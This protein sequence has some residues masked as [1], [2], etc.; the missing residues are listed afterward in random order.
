MPT[1]VASCF[2]GI[3]SSGSQS[4]AA[5]PVRSPSGSSIGW[6]L[7]CL[8]SRTGPM[9]GPVLL[10]DHGGLGGDVGRGVLAGDPGL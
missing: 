4:S 2:T 1:P 5:S 8:I 9:R 3:L 7:R 6:L 10:P